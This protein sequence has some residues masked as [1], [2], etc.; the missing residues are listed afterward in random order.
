[1]TVTGVLS[2]V[3]G[4]PATNAISFA[5]GLVPRDTARLPVTMPWQ[6]YTLRTLHI[7]LQIREIFLRAEEA[8]HN[9]S[10]QIPVQ[11]QKTYS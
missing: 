10:R 4:K 8:M 6:V 9:Y 5:R 3:G 2:E 1:M 7:Y 11:I